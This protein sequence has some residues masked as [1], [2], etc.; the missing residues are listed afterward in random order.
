MTDD[1][2]GVVMIVGA[3]GRSSRDAL[4]SSG[5]DADPRDP[6][7]RERDERAIDRLDRHTMSTTVA[8]PV[9]VRFAR[10]DIDL[11]LSASETRVA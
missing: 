6:G 10:I 2:A 8:G 11:V 7:R 4:R 1:G 3:N 5:L 9:E